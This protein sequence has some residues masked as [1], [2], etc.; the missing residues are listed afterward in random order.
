MWVRV[1]ML[2]QVL[3]RVWVWAWVRVRGC[4]RLRAW[5]RAQLRVAM[6]VAAA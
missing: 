4:V 6:V 1:L 5:V 3:M 2:A